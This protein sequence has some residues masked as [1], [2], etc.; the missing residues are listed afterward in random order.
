MP[1]F[2]K[3]VEI[4]IDLPLASIKNPIHFF[5]KQLDSYNEHPFW[6]AYKREFQEFLE[7]EKD[8]CAGFKEMFE[9]KY[10]DRGSISYHAKQPKSSYNAKDIVDPDL[11]F[12]K[13]HI[14]EENLLIRQY[15]ISANKCFVEANE[16]FLDNEDY[17]KTF[18]NSFDVVIVQDFEEIILQ[19]KIIIENLMNLILNCYKSLIDSLLT[20]RDRRRI[21]L[22]SLIDYITFI[23]HDLV[24]DPH[25][26]KFYEGA[27]KIIEKKAAEHKEKVWKFVK[28]SEKGI[29]LLQECRVSPEFYLAGISSYMPAITTLKSISQEFSP[30]RKMKII[31]KVKDKV[32]GAIVDFNNKK[33]SDVST[34]SMIHN[35]RETLDS[36][37]LISIFIYLIVASETTHIYKE[38]LFIETFLDEATL[39][40]SSES[41][42][43]IT[44]KAAV[45]Y[46]NGGSSRNL[47]ELM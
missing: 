17:N 37:H 29:D 13:R 11:L 25:Q 38:I 22:S 6:A 7:R 24:F 10:K 46:F 19:E 27:Q 35:L 23:M 18:A 20:S 1:S 28:N 9:L 14:S 43:Y 36:D 5:Q 31:L 42:Y 30:R 26:Y 45:D 4:L 8:Y 12:F 3:S 40:F 41:Y 39:N 34:T 16:N 32:W 2:L 47:I 15:L 21:S 33:T 44:F